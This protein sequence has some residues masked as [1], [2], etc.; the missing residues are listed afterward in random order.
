MPLNFSGADFRA[1]FLSG[2]R[3]PARRVRPARRV[4]PPS[5]GQPFCNHPANL[6]NSCHASISLVLLLFDVDFSPAALTGGD[7]LSTGNTT[8]AKTQLCLQPKAV[9]TEFDFRPRSFQ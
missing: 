4:G 8:A 2:G 9:P 6:L 3:T 7:L 1:F 5:P